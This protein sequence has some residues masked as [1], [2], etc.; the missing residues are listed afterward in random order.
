MFNLYVCVLS[1][2]VMSNSLLLCPWG[3][4]RQEYWNGLLCP[5][6]GDLLNPGIKPRSPALQ[7]DSLLSESPEKPTKPRFNVTA[8]WFPIAERDLSQ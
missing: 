2:S 3:F 8:V 4:S 5:P 6:S 7:S 1:H